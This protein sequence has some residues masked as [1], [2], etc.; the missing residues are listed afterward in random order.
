MSCPGLK[1]SECIVGGEEVASIGEFKTRAICLEDFQTHLQ[2]KK[3]R[4]IPCCFQYI[5]QS[6]NN[7][8]L[9]TLIPTAFPLKRATLHLP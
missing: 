4:F 8:F 3:K 2:K 7:L 1:Q 5:A 9:T 6:K